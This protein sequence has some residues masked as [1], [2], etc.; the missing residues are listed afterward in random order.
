MDATSDTLAVMT[1]FNETL[2]YE[3]KATCNQLAQELAVVSAFDQEAERQSKRWGGWLAAY[4]V[5]T[6]LSIFAVFFAANT[7]VMPVV[8]VVVVAAIACVFGAIYCGRH[9]L[10][11]SRRNIE[12]RRYELLSELI[13][14]LSIDIGP[15]TPVEV[16]LNGNDYHKPEYLSVPMDGSFSA[17]GTNAYRLPW[18]SVSG[19][20]LDG[21]RF[22][23]T[24]TQYVKRKER[25]KRKYTKVKEAVRE[26][27]EVELRCKR[28]R[29]SGWDRLPYVL[30]SI[31]LP[32]PLSSWDLQVNQDRV[33]LT[34][35]TARGVTVTGRGSHGSKDPGLLKLNA[36]VGLFTLLY[37]G[38]AEVRR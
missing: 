17:A 22:E 12:N 26:R 36:A 16:V 6:I 4:V 1:R 5:G 18:L 31:K 9:W 25:R 13:R 30:R 28:Q 37:R 3:Q 10:K 24:A 34:G 23:L 33:T 38:L 14:L 20:F 29:Y 8:I 32:L 27:V 11:W 7:K 35:W 19:E 15:Q 21:N 2:V